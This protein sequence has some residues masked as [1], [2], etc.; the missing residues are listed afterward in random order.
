MPKDKKCCLESIALVVNLLVTTGVACRLVNKTDRAS[1]DKGVFIFFK[2]F[3]L[4]NC[5]NDISVNANL[6]SVRLKSKRQHINTINFYLHDISTPL[7]GVVF[8]H[9]D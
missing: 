7:V 8:K 6:I 9:R 1:T 2:I 4:N 3:V 5:F